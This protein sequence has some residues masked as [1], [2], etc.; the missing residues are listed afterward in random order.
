MGKGYV[1]KPTTDAPVAISLTPDS[2]TLAAWQLATRGI[3]DVDKFNEALAHAIN[4]TKKATQTQA[5]REAQAQYTVKRDEIIKT[6][7]DTPRATAQRTSAVLLFTGKR[8][9][10][11][12]FIVKPKTPNRGF[13]GISPKQRPGVFVQI[14]KDGGGQ[15]P[16]LFVLQGI[17]KSPEPRVFS[18]AEY[19]K[20]SIFPE[21]GPGIVSM[22]GNEEAV[23][24]IQGRADEMLSQ[25]ID[26]EMKRILQK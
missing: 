3:V 1:F 22:V 15:A 2:G 16:H 4:R 14:R 11:L 6:I 23:A 24:A 8:I 17:G 18:R 19:H 26:H 9:P 12:K 13:K 5:V 7:Q 21:S 20:Y 25:R 10:L